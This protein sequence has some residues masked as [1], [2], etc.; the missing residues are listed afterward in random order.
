MSN[1]KAFFQ[2]VEADKS[3][4]NQI[5]QVD[6]D[7]QAAVKIAADAGFS[8]TAAEIQSTMDELYGDLSEEEL[9]RVAGGD[10]DGARF[11]NFHL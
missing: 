3:L 11:L 9:R 10:C 1:A 5:N 6:W 7:T 8:V 2:K 4:Q